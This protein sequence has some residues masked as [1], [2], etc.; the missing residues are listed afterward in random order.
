MVLAQSHIDQTADVVRETV[1]G[2]RPVEVWLPALTRVVVGLHTDNPRLHQ[3]LF[4]EAPR[5][6]ELLARFRQVE[7]EAV[8]AVAGLLRADAG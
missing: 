7:T 3:V 8:A 5:P 2:P 6:P 4:E 1:A